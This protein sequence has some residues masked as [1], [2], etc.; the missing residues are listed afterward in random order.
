[1]FR[2]RKGHL[3]R[4]IKKINTNQIQKQPHFKRH[5]ENTNDVMKKRHSISAQCIRFLIKLLPDH[6]PLDHR[7]GHLSFIYVYEYLLVPYLWLSDIILYEF[8]IYP[9]HA[10]CPTHINFP[11]VI[12]LIITHPLERSNR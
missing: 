12:T 11:F 1:M 6:R 5:E 7:G 9:M 3:I 8:I 2:S 10:A 4:T